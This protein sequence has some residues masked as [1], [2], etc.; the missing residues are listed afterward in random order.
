MIH[1]F[2]Y[3]TRII[4]GS[5]LGS[6]PS[7]FLYILLSVFFAAS[8]IFNIE[9][10]RYFLDDVLLNKNT[11][12]LILF[13]IAFLPNLIF[14]SIVCCTQRYLEKIAS[15]KILLDIQSRF[16]SN[17][18]CYD[19]DHL[20]SNA[21]NLSKSI[22][23]VRKFFYNFITFMLLVTRGS[24]IFFSLIGM[25]FYYDSSL[26][27]CALLF[28]SLMLFPLI[29]SS[30]ISA[31][32]VNICDMI[33]NYFSKF[34]NIY[35][36]ALSSRQEHH[37]NPENRIVNEILSLYKRINKNN[38]ISRTVVTVLASIFVAFIAFFGGERV[39]NG[40]ITLGQFLACSVAIIFCLIPIKELSK[41]KLDI[42]K[43]VISIANMLKELDSSRILKEDSSSTLSLVLKKGEIKFDSVSYS[44]D[45]RAILNNISFTVPASKT[46]ALVGWEEGSKKAIIDLLLGVSE[47]YSGS[48]TIDGQNIKD[49]NI[50]SLRSTIGAVS[51]DIFLFDDTIYANIAYAKLGA[52]REEVIDAAKSASIH[53]FVVSLPMGYNTVVGKQGIQLN[54]SQCLSIAIARAVLKNAPVLLLSSSMLDGIEHKASIALTYL[55]RNRTNLLI[56][57]R[58]TNIVN[59]NWIYVINKGS[60]IEHG[61]HSQ[62]IALGRIYAGLYSRNI[63]EFKGFH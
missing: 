43:D 18:L 19:L 30:R 13:S 44:L 39:I 31:V 50:K 35:L 24:T 46:V 42:S 34:D 10:V 54:A 63:G 16:Y 6:S 59:A 33:D 58:L 20:P 23:E 62:L 4:L 52:S 12:G 55:M 56:T 51:H 15:S 41:L 9:L 45:G 47:A 48:I 5:F 57:D 37:R 28:V 7:I 29:M 38:F 1:N 21:I 40:A 3:L 11:H 53:D 14:L 25:I 22:H 36:S 32:T 17:I 26:G 61:T 49:I 8:L 60:V 2:F 27:I